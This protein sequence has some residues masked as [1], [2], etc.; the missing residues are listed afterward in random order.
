MKQID[1][2]SEANVHGTSTDFISN[3][4]VHELEE[5]FEMEGWVDLVINGLCNPQ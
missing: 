3:F 5:R 4:E 2:T 1:E